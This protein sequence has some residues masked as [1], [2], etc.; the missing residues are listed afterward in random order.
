[1]T[2]DKIN[3]SEWPILHI[4][5]LN[6][7]SDNEEIDMFQAKFLALLRL[8]RD[9]TD[10]IPPEKI[11]L[12]MDMDGIAE[13]SFEQKLRAAAFIQDVREFVADTIFCTALITSSEI[14]RVVLDLIFKIQPLIS[15][16]KLFEDE[17]SALQWCRDNRARQLENLPPIY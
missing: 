6:A 5:I 13:A 15:L 3:T 17:N 7:P 1:M 2:F 14:V 8:A 16:N 10:G 12:V 9:G 4:S 11:C